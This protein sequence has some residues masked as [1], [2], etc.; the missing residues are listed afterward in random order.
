[1]LVVVEDEV[2]DGLSERS[3]LHTVREEKNRKSI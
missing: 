3:N 1:M 2:G